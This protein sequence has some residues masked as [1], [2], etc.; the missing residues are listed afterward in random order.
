MLVDGVDVTDETVG[1]TTTNL[2]VGAVQEVRVSQSLL[3]LSSGLASAGTV[4]VITK[5][6]ANDIHGQIFGNF[7][8]KAAGGANFPGG[9][10]NSYSREVF[11]GDV[12][13]A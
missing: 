2:T 11:G 3:P 12:G 7:R 10:D 1:A 6:G 4:N 8:D 9:E 5:T 13:G